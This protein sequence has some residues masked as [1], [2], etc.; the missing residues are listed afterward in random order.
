MRRDL[1]TSRLTFIRTVREMTHVGDAIGPS[2]C[3]PALRPRFGPVA[4][5]DRHGRRPWH[6]ARDHLRRVVALSLPQ[7][8]D[9]GLR[10]DSGCGDLDHGLPRDRPRVGRSP[11][12]DPAQ[13]H[14]PDG[15][16]GRGVDRIRR[17]RGDAG[18]DAVGLRAG[19][20]PRDAR[21]HTRRL[22]RHPDD[23][24]VAEGVHRQAAR[25]ASLPGG[26][27]LRQ[28]VDRWRARWLEREDRVFSASAWVSRIRWRCR[29]SRFGRRSGSG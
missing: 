3:L 28:G 12:D 13:Q 24:P 10:L 23:D 7:S 22:A 16:L 1:T 18:P 26:F 25:R 17:R 20:D 2:P 11:P 4:R 21:R 5:A 6:G 19:M 15:R 14:R 29:R 9:D 8:R 27:G